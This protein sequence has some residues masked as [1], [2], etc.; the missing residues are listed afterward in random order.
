[1][2]GK[3]ESNNAPAPSSNWPGPIYIDSSALVKLYLEEDGSSELDT[4]L[5]GRDDL[6]ISDLGIT[7]IVSAFAR[8]GREGNIPAANVGLVRG[9]ILQDVDARIFRLAQLTPEVHREAERLLM[10]LQ[11]Q[12]LRALD[13]LHVALALSTEAK[14]LI[15]FDKRLAEASRAIG[16]VAV[17]IY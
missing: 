2:I 10:A 8:R 5:V 3:T 7:E 11:N 4:I 17:P 6:V 9:R 12:P 15:T 1:M 13:A 14:T 16:L